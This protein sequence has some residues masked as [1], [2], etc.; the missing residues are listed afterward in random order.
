MAVD[1]ASEL[2]FVLDQ[3]LG[4]AMIEIVRLAKA[5]PVG[6]ITTLSELGY[7]GDTEDEDWMTDLGSRGDYVAVTRDSRILDAAVRRAAWRS[8]GIRILLLKDWGAAAPRA[9]PR[10]TLLVAPHG[11]SRRGGKPG[12]G[13]DRRL[14]HP[15]AAAGRDP[16]DPNG[17]ILARHRSNRTLEKVSCKPAQA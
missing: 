13:V 10:D 12:G 8:S 15:R 14:P 9:G 16:A 6:R 5:R 17:R 2:T 7:A 11:G 3:N 4:G 1:T